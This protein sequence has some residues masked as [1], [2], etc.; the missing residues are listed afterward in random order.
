MKNARAPVCV[1]KMCGLL[2][3]H[4]T[5]TSVTPPP[6]P[7]GERQYFGP[8]LTPTYALVSADWMGPFD[9]VVCGEFNG[10]C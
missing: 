9:R 3:P 8:R 6:T 1:R 4:R 7:G 5:Q 2:R 10:K